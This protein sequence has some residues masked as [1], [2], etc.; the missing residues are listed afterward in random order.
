[1]YKNNPL[2]SQAMLG[3]LKDALDGGAVHIFNGL[4]PANANDALDMGSTHTH[5]CTLLLD[6]TDGLELATPVGALISKPAGATWTGLNAF[7][8][9]DAGV[10]PLEPTFFRFCTAGDD[11]R[12]A[13][14][15]PRLQ[16][17]AGGPTSGAD[18]TL[19][20]DTLTDDGVSTTTALVFNYYIGSM[21]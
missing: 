13:G 14:S 17:S 9:A 11:G 2:L 20:S 1:M 10:G 3:A 19:G 4:E 15:A 12:G 18:A 7:D 21:G 5:L 16:G 6:G 8:G